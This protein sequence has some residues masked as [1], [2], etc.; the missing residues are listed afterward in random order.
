MSPNIWPYYHV[1][2]WGGS[3]EPVQNPPKHICLD[4][5]LR[6]SE[7]SVANVPFGFI[8]VCGTNTNTNKEKQVRKIYPSDI[9]R[10]QFETIRPSLEAARMV[11]KPRKVDLYDVF[12]GLLYVQRSGCQWRM[13]PSDY[14][15]W[16]TVY[17]YFQIWREPGEDSFSLLDEILKKINWRYSRISGQG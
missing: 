12:C 9:T 4:S 14:P 2:D 11:T 16:R 17:S 13:L 3:L 1:L 8:F 7:L 15:K 10:E 6:S 5:K